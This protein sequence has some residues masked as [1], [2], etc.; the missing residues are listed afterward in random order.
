MQNFREKDQ[1]ERPK[2]TRK[3]TMSI[4]MIESIIIRTVIRHR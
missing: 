4:F 3:A 1:Y 2:V